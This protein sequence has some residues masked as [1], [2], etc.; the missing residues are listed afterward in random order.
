MIY[1]DLNPADGMGANCCL[2]EIGPFKLVIDCGI[3]PKELGL[4]ATPNLNL[5]DGQNLDL[6]ILTHCHLDHLGALPLLLK[7]VPDVE[8]L[9][10]LPSQML[11]QRMLRNS[12]NVMQ[13]QPEEHY[14]PEYPLY[15]YEDID[16]L[17]NHV[18]P[19]LYG[20]TKLLEKQGEVL[21]V[22]LYSSGHVVGAAAIELVY[23]HRRIFFTGDVL[24]EQQSILQGAKFPNH[25]FDTLVMETTR[26]ATEADPYYNRNEEVKKLIE[27]VG[28]TLKSGGS[29]LIPV[30]A[31][32]RMQE[33][34]NLLHRA[35]LRGEIPDTPVFS[36]GLGMELADYIDK[37]TKRTELCTFSTKVIREMRVK[38]VKNLRPGK[39]VPIPGLYVC[40]SG[41]MV[42]HTPS[43]RVA[44]SLLPYHENLVCFVGYCDP[45]TPGG[46]LLKTKPGE[47][48]LFEALN[49]DLP[50]RA[51][52]RRF[53]LSG[54]ANREELMSLAIR[55]DPRS[56][57]LTHG[58]PE[59]REWFE[60]SLA[61]SVKPPQ[62]T[63]PKS[64]E[65]CLI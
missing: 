63:I 38:P 44:A 32:G 26:G 23:K 13:R 40:S 15:S 7:H 19:I 1:T 12:V 30:F 20:K 33:I 27:T 35:R 57:V 8:I 52:I 18:H 56:V 58:D 64:F 39:R 22:T 3:N 28:N 31:L 42:Q 11:Y 24:F 17:A 34:L 10:S 14:I 51:R 48:F 49:L 43:W 41:M 29:V 2:V 16:R 60:K 54:H 50:L 65:P 9:M 37:I 4:K 6:A 55:C 62:V 5:L 53:D 45:D 25:S 36:S 59:A 21:E 47:N 46:Q 61:N